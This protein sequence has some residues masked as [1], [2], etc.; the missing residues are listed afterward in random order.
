MGTTASVPP[1]GMSTHETAKMS[2]LARS[3]GVIFRASGLLSS[4]ILGLLDISP[5]APTK[6][7]DKAPRLIRVDYGHVLEDSRPQAQS[8]RAVSPAAS[9]TAGLRSGVAG[10]AGRLAG[11][12]V[13]LK[14]NRATSQRRF[15]H[16]LLA[17]GEHRPDIEHRGHAVLAL[18]LHLRRIMVGTARWRHLLATQAAGLL[19]ES[20]DEPTPA[21]AGSD[22]LATPQ[23]I[24]LTI[25]GAFGICP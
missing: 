20:V 2:R 12:G 3:G 7:R 21:A 18:L 19:S 8:Q 16:R 22:D 11:G 10:A 25:G 4:P 23:I 6:R 15:D 13:G 5:L 9:V 17:A 14:H 1:T 24:G